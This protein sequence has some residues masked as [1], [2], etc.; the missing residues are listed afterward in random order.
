MDNIPKIPIENTYGLPL[1]PSQLRAVNT[2]AEAGVPSLSRTQVDEVAAALK[3][4]DEGV[5]PGV[6][7]DDVALALQSAGIP[8]ANS[9]DAESI[10]KQWSAQTDE[11]AERAARQT[12]AEAAQ[13]AAKQQPNAPKPP[14]ASKPPIPDAEAPKPSTPE[15]EAPKS[16]DVSDAARP[17]EGQVGS[18][19]GRTG[20]PATQIEWP[21]K[22][23]TNSTQGHWETIQSKV[24]ELAASGEYEKIYV[25]K[26]ISNE[27]PGA[28]PNRRPDIMAVRRD[29]T[30]DQFEIPSKTDTVQGLYD[31]MTDTQ[32]LLG[33]KAGTVEVVLIPDDYS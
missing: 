10:V 30:I 29:G 2:L 16:A 21:N 20:A 5:P 27:V 32:S 13:Q 11:I 8:N 3:Q 1:E 17:G 23:H 22:P 14:E 31:R 24:Y 18:A 6:V 33:D 28:S 26:G 15:L 19:S 7:A 4:L 25:N 9:I 12:Q